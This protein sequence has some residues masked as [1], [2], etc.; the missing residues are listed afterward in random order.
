MKKDYITYDIPVDNIEGRF[1]FGRTFQYNCS[2]YEL[3]GMDGM[4]HK[5][6][7]HYAGVVNIARPK[8][9]IHFLATANETAVYEAAQI[10]FSRWLMNTYGKSKVSFLV[11][12]FKKSQNVD[13]LMRM[14]GFSYTPWTGESRYNSNNK[15]RAYFLT[16]G[17]LQKNKEMYKNLAKCPFPNIPERLWIKNIVGGYSG[18][19]VCDS[20]G[21]TIDSKNGIV[22]YDMI[23][24]EVKNG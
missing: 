6:Q 24:M 13:K 1:V 8:Y 11:A 21:S 23:K 16:S 19:V 3:S 22:K 15:M 2:A 14:M 5:L 4:L 7:K 17:E 9:P 18:F 20:E 12:T 10:L